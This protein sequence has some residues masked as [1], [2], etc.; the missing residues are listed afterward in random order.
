[1]AWAAAPFRSVQWLCVLLSLASA[2]GFEGSYRLLS[3]CAVEKLQQEGHEE[4]RE[5]EHDEHEEEHK[6]ASEKDAGGAGGAAESLSAF[7][8]FTREVSGS[9][10]L[11]LF[12]A[13]GLLQQ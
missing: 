12:L 10:N 2:A 9:R 6:E 3:G 13:F 7:G 1:M 11:L 5:E 8:K 4:E